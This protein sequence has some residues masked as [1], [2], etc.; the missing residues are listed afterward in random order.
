MLRITSYKPLRNTISINVD[1]IVFFI[2]Y[3]FLGSTQGT[4]LMQ[5]DFDSKTIINYSP[6]LIT[7]T[8]KM[9]NTLEIQKC[10]NF[11]F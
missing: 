4:V 9:R 2:R 11:I 1:H 5:L 6:N 3:N 8:D 7:Y 10:F